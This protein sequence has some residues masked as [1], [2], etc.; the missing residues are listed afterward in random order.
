TNAGGRD[1]STLTDT[2]YHVFLIYNPTGPVVDVM[3]SSSVSAPVLPSGYTLFRRI[4]SVIRVASALLP[5]RQTGN[6]FIHSTSI[7][8]INVTQAAAR[9]TFTLTVPRDI[10]PL[11]LIRVYVGNA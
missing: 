3:F 6:M 2:T 1:T 9:G 11:A 5:F 4:G 8:D 10:L 7:F